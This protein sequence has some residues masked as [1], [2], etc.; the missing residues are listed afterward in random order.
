MKTKMENKIDLF[1]SFQEEGEIVRKPNLILIFRENKINH[2][3]CFLLN[4]IVNFL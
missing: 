4:L 3:S 1:R 2:L